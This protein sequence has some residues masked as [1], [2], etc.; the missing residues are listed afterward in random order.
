MSVYKY[1]THVLY[2]NIN[3]W[4]ADYAWTGHSLSVVATMHS[5]YAT[6][7]VI[8]EYVLHHKQVQ[9]KKIKSP[10]KMDDS[11]INIVHNTY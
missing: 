11:I 1:Y 2:N 9:K 7:L 3:Q 4:R 10:R 6:V 8:N 5:K